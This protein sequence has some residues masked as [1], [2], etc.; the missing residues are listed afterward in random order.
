[1]NDFL[2]KYYR[3]DNTISIISLTY[4]CV[5]EE[6]ALGGISVASVTISQDVNMMMMLNYCCIFTL[7]VFDVL[8]TT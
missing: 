8:K 4:S 5:G 2:I 6:E 1:M 7:K 3:A